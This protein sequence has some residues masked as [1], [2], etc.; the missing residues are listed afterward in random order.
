M[1]L[2]AEHGFNNS[3]FTLRNIIST[4]SDLYSGVL[5]ALGSLKG[6]LHGGASDN[7]IKLLIDME[8]KKIYDVDQIRDFILEYYIKH[9]KKVPGFGHAVYKNGDPRAYI[10]KKTVV[11]TIKN[12][13]KNRRMYR[14]A[15]NLESVMKEVKGKAC[16]YPNV[17]Y[18]ASLLYYILGI[19]LGMNIVM[20]ANART[21]GWIAHAIEQSNDNI[22]YRPMALY[23]GKE[24]GFAQSFIKLFFSIFQ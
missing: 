4:G 16:L 8:K 22:L 7:V 14:I 21:A 23:V 15:L 10:L 3:T 11:K 20:F 17:D 6:P 2:H 19:P 24:Q 13:E 18:W 1:W 12:S 5:G 9:K